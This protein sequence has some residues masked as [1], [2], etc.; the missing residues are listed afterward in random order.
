[1]KTSPALAVAVFTH[2]TLIGLLV[3]MSR[4]PIVGVVLPLLLGVG[5]YRLL[6]TLT[7]DPQPPSAKA[8]TLRLPP[9]IAWMAALWCLIAVL[10]VFTGIALRTGSIHFGRAPVTTL[11]LIRLDQQPSARIPEL[12]LVCGYYDHLDLTLNQKRAL[13]PALS[14]TTLAPTLLL[15]S[16]KDF[17]STNQGASVAKREDYGVYDFHRSGTP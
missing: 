13:V 17:F 14:D 10:S 8:S 2:A 7:G 4:S 12:I 11:S 3:G 6:D 15:S 5:G 1:M 9:V 16:L